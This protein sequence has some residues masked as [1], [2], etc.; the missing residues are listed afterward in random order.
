MLTVRSGQSYRCFPIIVEMSPLPLLKFAILMS[1]I[2]K[3]M[4]TCLYGRMV[5]THNGR[6][7]A[8]NTQG[9]W[10]PSPPPSLAQAIASILESWDEQ[11]ELLR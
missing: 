11:T 1:W 10:N 8:E 4:V 5:N 2:S 9:N 3:L 6:A 7:R